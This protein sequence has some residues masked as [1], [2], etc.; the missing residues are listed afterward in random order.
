MPA[1]TYLNLLIQTFMNAVSREYVRADHWHSTLIVDTGEVSPVDFSLSART[2]MQLVQA[3]FQ[4]TVSYL[5]VK[6]ARMESSGKS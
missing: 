5:P 4:A 3:G 2:K 6:L 1:L